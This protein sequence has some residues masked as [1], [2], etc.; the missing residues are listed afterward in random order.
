MIWPLS[1]RVNE[2]KNQSTHF[3]VVALGVCMFDVVVAVVVVHRVQLMG[4]LMF[5][6]MTC[7]PRTY[8]FVICIVSWLV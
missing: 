2:N 8:I 7:E 4:Y 5:S 3:K 1:E 6:S